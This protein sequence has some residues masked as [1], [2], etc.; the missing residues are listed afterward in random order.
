MSPQLVRLHKRH[1]AALETNTGPKAK[2]SG[3]HT[4]DDDLDTELDRLERAVLAL[5]AETGRLEGKVLVLERIPWESIRLHDQRSSRVIDAYLRVFRH[6][7]KV[8]RTEEANHQERFLRSICRED[9]VFCGDK[10]STHGVDKLIHA[11]RM[12]SS[13][14][15]NYSMQATCMEVVRND[16]DSCDLVCH[17]L[18]SVSQRLTRSML[19]A[20]YPH[21]MNQ[22]TLVQTLIG[23]DI[24]VDTKVTFGFSPCGLV[25]VYGAHMNREKAFAQLLGVDVAAMLADGNQYTT[26]VNLP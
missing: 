1:R 10:W 21:I 13:S 2:V 26:L 23:Q 15:T 7:F 5:E 8:R 20:Y 12:Y 25:D 3:A 22:E 4:S 24:H 18:C 11:F 17:V 9:M 14:H 16:E 6:G 19:S